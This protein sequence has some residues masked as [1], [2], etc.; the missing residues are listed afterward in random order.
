MHAR[1]A[2]SGLSACM[3]VGMQLIPVPY[4]L[5]VAGDCIHLEEHP[6]EK[7]TLLLIMDLIVDDRPLSEIAIRLNSRGLRT[8]E[9]HE[10][11]P[12]AIFNLLPRTVDAGP[13]MFT[14]DAWVEHRQTRKHA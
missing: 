10:W 14:S 5:R 13:R 9:G 12:V 7:V 4:G 1:G 3:C 6:E 8:R 11:T 2:L